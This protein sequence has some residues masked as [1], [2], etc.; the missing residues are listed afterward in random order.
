MFAPC[1][2]YTDLAHSVDDGKELSLSNPLIE[3]TRTSGTD[4]DLQTGQ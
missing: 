3:P 2:A 4:R 1:T